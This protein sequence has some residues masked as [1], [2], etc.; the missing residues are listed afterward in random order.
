MST[1][2]VN[3]IEPISGNNIAITG[4]LTIIGGTIIGT[5]TNATTASY[6]TAANVDGTVT[7]AATASYVTT[8]QTASYVNTLNQ[9][10]T[11]SGSILISGSFNNS[12]SLNNS[13]S[14]RFNGLPTS[15]AGL[16]AGDIWNDSGTLKIV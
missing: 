14:I 10:V 9:N 7:N 11:I 2:K 1:L 4:D 15:A 12:G 13:G 6:V 16:V 3:A 8:A 5:I